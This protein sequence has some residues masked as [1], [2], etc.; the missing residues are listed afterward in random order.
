MLQEIGNQNWEFAHRLFQIVAAASRPLHVEE[1]A[2]FLAFDFTVGS[3]PTLLADWRPEDPAHAVLSTCSSLLAIVDVD[4]FSVIQFSHFSV[5]EY[6]TSQRLAEARHTISRFH[7]SMTPAHTIVVQACLGVLLQVDENITKDG[8]KKFPLARYA[9][10]HW[11]GH[12]RFKGVSPNIQDGMKRLFDQDKHHFAVWVWIYDPES[13]FPR[14]EVYVQP[15]PTRATPL[16]YAAFCGLQDMVK[17]LI[18]E[19][20][21]NVHA[22]GFDDDETLLILASREGHSEVA[23]VLLEHGADIETRSKYEWSPLEQASS[24]GHIGVVQVLLEHGADVKAVDTD[25]R[26][27]LHIASDSGQATAARVLLE[28]GADANAKRMDDQTPLHRATSEGVARVLFEYGADTSA[29]DSDNRT[30][31]YRALKYGRVEVTRVLLAN[32]ADAHSLDS[33]N[34]TP[35]HLASRRGYVDP[36]RWLLQGNYDIHTQ[37]YK[38]QTPF[39]VASKKEHYDVMQLLLEHGAEDHRS[40]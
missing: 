1:L 36:V 7:V 19:R 21:Q 2:E 3:T 12:A 17:F 40:Q 27:A 9:A 23:R 33:K 16:H 22:S 30:P 10:E 8:L 18:V 5:K 31:L 37:D 11:V 28:H 24:H 15:P 34:K 4:G 32:G 38:G 13:H 6:L 39:Q 29:R 35:L 26:T 25:N 20:S 14:Y